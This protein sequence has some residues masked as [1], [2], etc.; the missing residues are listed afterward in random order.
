MD[1]NVLAVAQKEY[2]DQ[3]NDVMLPFLIT[4]FDE[5]YTRAHVDSK[6]KDTLIVFQQYLKD[7]KSWNQGILRERTDELCTSCAYFSDL[8]AAIIV[9]YVKILSSVR[10]KMDKQKISIKLPK[11]DDFIFRMYE[12]VAKV[13]YKSPYWMAEKLTEDDKIDKMRPIS[14]KCMENVVKTLVPVQAILEAYIGQKGNLDVQSQVD[15]DEDPEDPEVLDDIPNDLD[16]DK[17]EEGEEDIPVD[18]P[19]AGAPEDGMPE[20]PSGEGEDMGTDSV[21]DVKKIHVAKPPPGMEDNSGDDSD[22]DLFSGL[23]D[24]K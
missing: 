21:D 13:L 19:G 24:K 5:M 8:L 15:P 7:I 12:E 17:K 23:R 1:N 18:L 9:G 6:G 3:M 20:D 22:D 4:N 16:E 2:M 10:L 11:T 14:A